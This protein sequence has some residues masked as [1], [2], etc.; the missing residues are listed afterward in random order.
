MSTNYNDKIHGSILGSFIGDSIGFLFEGHKQSFIKNYLEKIRNYDIKNYFRGYD[1][2]LNG[3]IYKDNLNKCKWS[4]KFGQITD[5]SQL[6]YLI[7]ENIIKNK[8]MFLIKEFGIGISKLFENNNIVGY[9]STTKKFAENISRGVHHKYSAVISKSNGSLMR[10]DIF[11]LLLFNKD[12]DTL[13]DCVEK[14]ALLTHL[15]YKTLS[16]CLCSAFIIKYIMNN[17]YLVD[18]MLLYEIYIKINKINMDVAN[19]ILQMKEIIQYD[20]EEAYNEIKKY[21]SI[22]WGPETLSSCALTTLLWALYSFLKNKDSFEEC[23]LTALKVGGDVDTIAKIACSFSGCYLG[24]KKIPKEYINCLHDK[25][26]IDILTMKMNINNLIS[27][28]QN[29]KITYVY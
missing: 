3:P 4:F 19:A 28:I 8:G 29:K 1:G 21:E 25:K 26:R 14:Q 22:I 20:F 9:G 10:S 5:D 13:F 23:L 12:N 11:G 24:I 16:C 17:K 18:D 6:T 15:N 2:N 7:I 27:L